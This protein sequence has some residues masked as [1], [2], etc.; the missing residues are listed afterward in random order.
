MIIIFFILNIVIFIF[1]YKTGTNH[2]IH[3]AAESTRDIA[4][5]LSPEAKAE[6]D[7]IV[8]GEFNKLGGE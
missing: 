6:F 3:I 1:G 2:A 5:K 7:K 8:H 4:S